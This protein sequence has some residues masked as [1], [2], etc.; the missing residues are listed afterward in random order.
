MSPVAH[1]RL[2]TDQ[3]I[4]RRMP[5]AQFISGD[6]KLKLMFDYWQS[7][8]MNGLLPARRDV[9]ILDLR[10]MVGG[11]HLLDASAS[12]PSR[13]VFRVYGSIGSR[14]NNGYNYTNTTIGEYPSEAYRLALIEDYGAVAFTGTAA[15]HHVVALLDFIKYSYSR[16]ILPLADDGRH[17]NMLMVGIVKRTFDDLRVG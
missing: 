11:I 6:E 12:D 13:F 16:L 1:L 14:L 15:Y 5:T 2:G 8:R 9:D 4:R 7:R 3:V 10:P 17:V